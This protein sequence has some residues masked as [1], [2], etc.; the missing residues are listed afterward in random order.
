MKNLLRPLLAAA[1][2]SSVPA[3]NV[4]SVR[5]R[6]ARGLV[7]GVLAVSATLPIAAL[8]ASGERTG[9][10]LPGAKAS[11]ES[12]TYD[13]FTNFNCSQAQFF[14]NATAHFNIVGDV[15]LDGVTKL[16]GTQY[17]TYSIPVTGGPDTFITNFSRNFTPPPPGSSTYTFVFRSTVLQGTRRIGISETTI[18]CTNGALSAQN[19]WIAGGEP[20][21]AGGPASWAALALL[22]AAAAAVR[23]AP[24]RA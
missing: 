5:A 4:V 6:L 1:G 22:L 9:G 8:A 18:V 7:A 10:S 20:I 24:R 23:L 14:T 16:D 11:G 19:I 13:N 3:A 12:F 15:V 17:D 2:R 21:P